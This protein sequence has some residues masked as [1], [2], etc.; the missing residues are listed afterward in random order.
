MSIVVFNN[1]PAA[2]KLALKIVLCDHKQT[3][4]KQTLSYIL[5]EYF[6]YI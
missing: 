1:L 4:N 3:K 5:D 6:N 2:F